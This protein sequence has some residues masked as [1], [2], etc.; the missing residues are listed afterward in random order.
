MI[1]RC[2]SQPQAAVEDWDCEAESGVQRGEALGAKPSSLLVRGTQRCMFRRGQELD[3]L[4]CDQLVIALFRGTGGNIQD[5]G[6]NWLVEAFPERL[7][8]GSRDKLSGR[9]LRS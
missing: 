1:S 4:R 8:Q 6:S 5:V 7:A 3:D 2:R 9:R